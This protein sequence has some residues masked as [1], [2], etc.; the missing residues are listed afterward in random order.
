MRS[1]IILV[2]ALALTAGTVML[3]PETM[4]AA[5]ISARIVNGSE[6]SAKSFQSDWPFIVAIINSSSPSQ[7]AG[8]NCGG[9]L[10]DDQHVITAAHCVTVRAGS[11]IYAPRS[12]DIMAG[13][14]VLDR[15]GKGSGLS[16][17]R[18]VREIFVHPDYAVNEG[19][20]F[21][22][23]VA[24]LRLSFPVSDASTIKIV[25]PDEDDLWGLGEGNRSA[26]VAGW[27]D[28]DPEG[29]ANPAARY[30]VNLHATNVPI[31]ADA[32]CSS[33]DSGGYGRFYERDTNICAGELRTGSTLGTDA[34]QGDSGGPLVV[35]TSTGEPRLAGLVSWGEGC[36]QDNLGAYAR[37]A[38]MR[39]WVSSIP[40][41]TDNRDSVGGPGD[42][43]VV[44][45]P[46]ASGANY[47]SVLIRWD[48]PSAGAPPERYSVWR[49]S[50]VGGRRVDKLHGITRSMSYTVPVP[51]TR[52]E[53][54]TTWVVRPVHSDGSHGPAATVNASPLLDTLR[55][56]RP[57][58]I[59]LRSRTTK[60]VNIRWTSAIDRQ[61]GIS[62]YQVQMRILERSRSFRTFTSSRTPATIRIG[63]LRQGEHVQV[64]IRALD[65]AGNVGL[66]RTSSSFRAMVR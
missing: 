58:H 23:D 66:W 49:R 39:D 26:R 8:Q 65:R 50:I 20:A 2:V 19:D 64:R 27:G 24:I 63:A 61:S 25:G 44:T 9:A 42:L 1:R 10:I 62:H 28:T 59:V 55:P 52:V 12:I 4:I 7:F 14:P 56:G 5:P 22:F 43:H 48:A 3:T 18:T 15:Y 51:P 21:R 30:P 6:V 31:H 45:Q 40:G 34:C 35:T 33:T 37:L 54:A 36:A 17:N 47:S 32:R 60:A 13:S 16:A 57:R 11:Q 53:S 38:A 29:T 41:A 46:R